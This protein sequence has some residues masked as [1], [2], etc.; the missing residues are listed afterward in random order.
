M[1]LKV[2]CSFKEMLKAWVEEGHG[3]SL[4][5]RK[6]DTR[7][8]MSAG[9]GGGGLTISVWP[10]AVPLPPQKP[11]RG[12]AGWCHTHLL[13]QAM[14]ADNTSAGCSMK[15]VI[16]SAVDSRNHFAFILQCVF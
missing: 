14:C 8:G 16:C 5:K 4:A 6:C 12:W 3:Q 2:G 1:L 15:H 9:A 7:D 11:Q 13:P 10:A